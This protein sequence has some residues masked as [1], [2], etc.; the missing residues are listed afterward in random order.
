MTTESERYHRAKKRVDD[1]KG[2]Y[3]HAL[4]YLLVN[5]GLFILDVMTPGGPWF[6]WTLIGWGIGLGVHGAGVFLFPNFPG[7]AWEE[8]KIREYMEKDQAK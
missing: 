7:K 4:I 3:G 1:E 2:F 5:V 6:Y 8:R